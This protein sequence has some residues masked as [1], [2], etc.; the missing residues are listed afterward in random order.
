MVDDEQPIPRL[1]SL[2][3]MPRAS[4]LARNASSAA[5]AASWVS[6]STFSEIKIKPLPTLSW[7]NVTRRHMADR[8][9]DG[10][11]DRWVC[12]TH[13]DRLIGHARDLA[14]RARLRERAR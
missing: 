8:H 12:D 10:C 3:E 4:S 13:L 7:T 1:P 6:G 5:T 14:E 9:G 11:N 2:T